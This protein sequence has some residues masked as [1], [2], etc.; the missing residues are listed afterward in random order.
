[1]KIVT[2]GILA[3]PNV[4]SFFVLVMPAARY[5]ARKLDWAVLKT[6]GLRFLAAGYVFGSLLSTIANLM[7]GFFLAA[8]SVSSLSRKPTVTMMLQFA[9]TI[10]WMFFAK[11]AAVWDSTSPVSMPNSVLASVRPLYEVWL[12]PLSSKPPESETMQALKSPPDALALVLPLGAADGVL[13][14]GAWA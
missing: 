4:P 9:S 5:P 10:D 3:P 2:V 12:N 11:S 7:S 8:A 6:S 14:P 13:V 1:M